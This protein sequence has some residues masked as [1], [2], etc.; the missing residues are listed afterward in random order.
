MK[1]QKLSVRYKKPGLTTCFT[2]K[3]SPMRPQLICLLLAASFVGNATAVAHAEPK[4]SGVAVDSSDWPW[5]RGPSRNG[6][7]EPDQQPPTRWNDTKNVL[8]KTPVPGRG[9][10]SPTVL[11]N[12]IFLATADE[13]E[14]VQSVLCFDRRTGKRLWKT[15]VHRGGFM[16]ANKKASH[17]SSTVACD[18][19]TVF[20]NFPNSGAV[21]TTALDLDGEQLWQTKITDYKVHQGYGSSPA[22]YGPLVIVSADNKAGGAVAGLK[23]TTG[24]VVWRIERP[25]KPNYASPIVLKAGERE[26]LFM[27]GCDLV[28]G[29]DPLTGKKLWET[30]GATTECVTSTPTDGTH[31][32]TSGG[33]P[34]NHVSAVRADGSGK[35]AWEKGVRVYVPSMLVYRGYLFGVTDS[36]VAFCWTSSTGEE[37]WNVRLGGTFST[38][39]VLV[40]DIL[41][42]TNERGECF[43][44]RAD[45]ES[46]KI[47]AKN[48]LGDEVF[49]TPTIVNSRIYH[50]V[51]HRT[52]SKRQEMLYCIGE[53]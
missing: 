52:G 47:V 36:G 18:G 32:F 46:F 30:K 20:I 22:V 17:A 37:A 3:D 33:Y 16:K 24:E 43:V 11:G 25:K 12:R 41:Y 15:D 28:T 2:S 42:A 29:I 48:P 10:G 39:P 7:A 38:S 4:P 51:A 8:W 34:R 14:Q 26:Q 35:V 21:Y 9:H 5:W 6:I 50:R 40:G 49:A 31:I 1:Q 27:I 53:K 23:R 44:Y 45:P 13:K 19:E